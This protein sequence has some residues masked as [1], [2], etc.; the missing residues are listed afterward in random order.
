MLDRTTSSVPSST[1]GESGC[2]PRARRRTVWTANLPM[3]ASGWRT[4]VSGGADQRTSGR[5]SWKSPGTTSVSSGSM[6]RPAAPRGSRRGGRGSRA[7]GAGPRSGRSCGGR[8]RAGVRWPPCHRTSWRRRP[9]ARR[10]PG[11]PPGRRPPVG[12]RGCATP[13]APVE[14]QVQ[15]GGTGAGGGGASAV[16]V[17][18]E[19]VLDAGAGRG[20]H[21]GTAVDDLV[22]CPFAHP[23][24]RF[25][26]RPE[27]FRKRRG[28]RSTIAGKPLGAHAR[29][30]GTTRSDRPRTCV[31]A[32]SQCSCD[33]PLKS[34]GGAPYRP[35]V[36]RRRSSPGWC[37]QGGAGR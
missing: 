16:A 30:R 19:Q 2:S 35:V 6:R 28:D 34:P 10:G 15:Q 27:V 8:A 1:R 36:L 23:R 29:T 11:S 4:V 26:K 14:D 25:S 22:C 3:S 7:A 33:R 21:V 5:S 12:R 17:S 9:R 24:R 20:R 18:E 32:G 13:R 31:G 37:P